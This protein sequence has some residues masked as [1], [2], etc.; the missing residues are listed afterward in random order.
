M[1]AARSLCE[2][3]SGREILRAK[4]T[5]TIRGSNDD[6]GPGWFDEFI[7]SFDQDTINEPSVN[8]DELMLTIRNL[9][10]LECLVNALD[11]IET[12]SSLAGL[13]RK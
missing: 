9:W 2:R 10:E 5:A 3:V 13:H 4:T 7:S 6:S 8:L 12:L 11:A 1:R